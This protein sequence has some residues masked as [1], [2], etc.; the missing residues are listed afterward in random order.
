MSLESE[1]RALL[2]KHGYV[3]AMEDGGTDCEPYRNL[4]MNKKKEL[5]IEI[6]WPE[7]DEDGLVLDEVE[8]EN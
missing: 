2:K 7:Y 8:E 6:S 1:L 3:L 4:F 5:A